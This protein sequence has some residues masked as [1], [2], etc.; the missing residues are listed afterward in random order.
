MAR[1]GT[2]AYPPDWPDI[3]RAVKDAAGWRCVRCGHPHDRAS[4]H[5]LTVHHLNLDKADCRWWNVVALC[6]RCHLAVQ[7]KIVM[8][9]PW[10]MGE[11]SV[12]FRPYAAGWYAW[13]YLGLDLTRA[14]VEARLDELLSLERRAVLGVA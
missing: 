13:R 9:R 11:H 2:N 6:Q 5:V 1:K 4:G 12:W 14:E 8:E 10:V 7:H 3:A